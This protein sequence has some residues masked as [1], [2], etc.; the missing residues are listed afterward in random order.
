[1][2]NSSSVSKLDSLP[3][4]AGAKRVLSRLCASDQ[5]SHAI[6]FY[7]PRGV[8]KKR[9]AEI[10]AQAWMCLAP[11]S[12]G[13]C[14]DCKVCQSFEKGKC[15]D[16]LNIEP[17]PPSRII[18]LCYIVP[19]ANN[20]DPPPNP[21]TDFLRVGPLAARHKVA[22]IAGADRMNDDAANALLKT[23]EEPPPYAKLI[24]LTDSV[25]D[26]LPTILSRCLAIQC[27]L[28]DHY[29]ADEKLLPLLKR[30]QPTPGQLA[31]VRE[32]ED[33]FL[34]MQAFALGL[35]DRPLSQ[36]IKIS[37]DFRTIC[38]AR[39]DL[40]DESKR[41]AYA[42]GLEVLGALLPTP[43]FTDEIVEAHRRILGNGNASLVTDALFSKILTAAR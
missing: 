41:Y 31:E 30:L 35:P 13:S 40:A 3:G 27:E 37:E 16:L 17:K 28:P 15:V 14:G 25:T 7:G 6:L 36:A 20:D 2:S 8:G 10:I 1:M 39:R 22:I 26:V 23:L 11:T 33:F 19:S 29:E 38:E 34:Q 9:L 12:E 5:A 18:R 42:T 43:D 32:N 21:L 4:L 24:L